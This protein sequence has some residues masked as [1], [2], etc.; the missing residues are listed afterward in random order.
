ML[1]L[2]EDPVKDADGNVVYYKTLQE[3]V[4]A[5]A[6]YSETNPNATTIQISKV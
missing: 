3:A 6:D 1:M 4:D 5:V 2:M